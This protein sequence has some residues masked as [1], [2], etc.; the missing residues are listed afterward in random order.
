MKLALLFCLIFP[1]LALSEMTSTQ[2]CAWDP[3]PAKTGYGFPDPMTIYYFYAAPYKSGVH[4]EISDVSLPAASFFNVV[5]YANG[6]PNGGGKLADYEIQTARNPY[7]YPGYQSRIP[8]G[9]S[10]PYT[11]L[12]GDKVAQTPS[13]PN[14][15]KLNP[16]SFLFPVDAPRPAQ[17]E[18]AIRNYGPLPAGIKPP[19]LRMIET[20]TGKVLNCPKAEKLYI[21]LTGLVKV[22]K[23]AP[24]ASRHREEIRMAWTAGSTLYP[25]YDGYLGAGWNS[26]GIALFAMPR[27]AYPECLETDGNCYLNRTARAGYTSLVLGDQLTKTVES[28]N[29]RKFP[30]QQDGAVYLAFINDEMQQNIGIV[31][32]LMENGFSISRAADNGV[33]I[34]VHR[35]KLPAEKDFPASFRMIPP[36]EGC[37][38]AAYTAAAPVG[39]FCA[40]PTSPN[41]QSAVNCILQAR[42]QLIALRKSY[43]SI[44]PGGTQPPPPGTSCKCDLASCRK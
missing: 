11:V 16:A 13:Q 30:P 10:T 4:Y 31:T 18:L 26:S 15:I 20:A 2:E 34:L 27:P 42:S 36:V 22:G 37:I 19:R 44:R 32:A 41:D 3:A 6:L 12:V 24:A 7:P 39:V 17:I 43:E 21:D 8:F 38:A 29:D 1:A 40:G 14:V 28:I 35:Q 5:A 25:D 9:P 33:S 23:G